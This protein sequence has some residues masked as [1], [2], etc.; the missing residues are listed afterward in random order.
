M[1]YHDLK[2]ENQLAILPGSGKTYFDEF[3]MFYL[4]KME[5]HKRKRI[6]LFQT[7]FPY[8]KS[9]KQTISDAQNTFFNLSEK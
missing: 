3:L 7:Y 1:L 6:F 9:L 5:T 2:S 4:E 8:Q